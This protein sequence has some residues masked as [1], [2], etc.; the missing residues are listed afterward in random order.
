MKCRRRST[1]DRRTGIFR[2]SFV[3]YGRASYG[4]NGS[5]MSTEVGKIAGASEKCIR[6]ADTSSEESG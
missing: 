4:S 3:T 1:G 2:G 5:R 6:E